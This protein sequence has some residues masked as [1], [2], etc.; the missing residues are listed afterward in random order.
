MHPKNDLEFTTPIRDR[1]RQRHTGLRST[2]DPSLLVHGLLDLGASFSNWSNCHSMNFFVVVDATVEVVDEYQKEIVKLE[3]NILLRPDMNTVRLRA[4]NSFHYTR[5]V[6]WR[7]DYSASS[8]W[9]LNS[10]QTNARAY[11]NC[12]LWLEAL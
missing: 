9:G 3:H 10:P 1:L 5:L 4:Y 7:G 8:L 11:Q 2:A 12:H 6:M